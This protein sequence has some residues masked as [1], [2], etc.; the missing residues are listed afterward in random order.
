MNM[1][2]FGDESG[3]F[4]KAHQRY[5]VFGG[6][7]ILSKDKLKKTRANFLK[8]EATIKNSSSSSKKKGE[9]KG[10][11]ME[12][13]HKKHL[14]NVTN[15]TIRY[16]FVVDLAKVNSN[17]FKNKKSKQRYLDYV[18]AEGLRRV[19][20]RLASKQT[21]KPS[22]IQSVEILFDAHNTPTNGLYELQEGLEEALKIG[23]CGFET[24]TFKPG[25]LSKM[26]GNVS[27]RF[28]NSASEP[29]IRAADIMANTAYMKAVGKKL[30][31]LP[32][33]VQLLQFP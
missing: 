18:Y 20:Q 2:I 15:P 10:W 16:A 26:K 30:N 12:E 7:I 28:V 17:V 14:L 32:A 9:L 3:V 19:L 25:A 24:N 11:Q 8:A 6:L 33:T 5:L 1:Y 27:L 23:T 4:D 22:E 13:R 29:L 21:I 31:S